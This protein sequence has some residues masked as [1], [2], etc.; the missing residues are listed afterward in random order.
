MRF[1]PDFIEKVRDANNVVDLISQHTQLRPMA[2]GYMGRCPFPDHQEKTPSFSVSETKQVYNCFGCHKKGNI[3][4]FVQEFMGMNFPEAI[5]YLANRANI[6]LPEE[7]HQENSQ[8]DQLTKKKKAILQLNKLALQYF[9]ESYQR[10]PL[11]SPVRQYAQEKRGLSEETLREFSVG[12]APKEWD[13]LVHFLKSKGANL[14]LAEEARLI[15][16]RHE[17][18]GYIDIFRERLM[19][20]IFN[21]MNEPVAFGGRI[22]AQGE[23]KYLNSG[24]TL[25]FNKGKI[26]YG[27][28][29]TAKHIRSDDQALVVEG[30]MDLVSLHQAGIKTAVAP[31]GTALTADQCRLLS[32]MTKNVIVLFD[33]DEAGQRAAERSL[34]LLLASE[35]HPKGLILPDGMDPDD[36]VKSQGA[37]ALTTLLANSPDLFSMVLGIWTRGYRGEASDKVKMSDLLIPIFASMQDVRIKKLYLQEAASKLGVEETWLRDAIRGNDG[38]RSSA[39]P[40]SLSPSTA[41]ADLVPL[42]K[43]QSSSITESTPERVSIK[44]A[45]KVEALVLSLSLK[46]ISNFKYLQESGA[47]QFLSHPGIKAVLEKAANAY[48]QTPER[49]DKLA[50]LLTSFV[51][52]PELLLADSVVSTS[53]NGGMG[54]QILED[55]V[56]RDIAFQQ[57]RESEIETEKKMLSDCVKRLKAQYLKLQADQLAADIKRQPTPEKLELLMSI[58]RDRLDLN[59]EQT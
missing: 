27:L 44:G 13:G 19:F 33:G 35:V 57:Q 34:P 37:E 22:I 23:P 14:P 55:E 58:Q 25:V 47:I 40:Q 49:F 7:N 1:S 39:K 20:P 21:P 38:R 32:R 31:M 18:D 24:E 6:T 51:D 9:V 5:E 29:Q 45:P 26:L 10:L 12:Y 43:I 30:Y 4:T 16:R 36:F 46:N 28:S 52:A 48:R 59:K 17:G 54:S 42:E 56:A 53:S 3:F 41:P 8:Q 15:K 11:S 50:G 2:G